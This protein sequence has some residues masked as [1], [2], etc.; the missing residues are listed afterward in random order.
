M[1]LR[2]LI[3]VA[4]LALS[5]LVGWGSPGQAADALPQPSGPVVLEIT[6]SIRNTNT[7]GAA[8]F[9]RQMIEALGS[10]KLTTS[11]AWTTGK[12]E[13]EGIFA[14]DLLD[15]VGAEGTSVIATALND[16]A[17]SIPLQELRRYPVLL[18]LKMN[19]EYLKIRD[20]GPIWI[21]YPRDQH[22]E[23]QDS[24]TDKK[25]IWQLSSLRIE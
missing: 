9:D 7:D 10:G 25:W 16:Y 3:L 23:L 8:R 21:V 24:L 15:V 1:S 18:A 17:V 5:L 20:K 6:G 19:G 11:S 4:S 2:N 13:F 12:A 22:K 14:R